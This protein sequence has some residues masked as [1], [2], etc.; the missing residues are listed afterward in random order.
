MTPRRR[1]ARPESN[2]SAKQRVRLSAQ[3][4][5]RFPFGVLIVTLIMRFAIAPS[6]S[7]AVDVLIGVLA[8]SVGVVISIIL[9][10]A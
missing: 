1:I 3:S 2:G 8:A 10:P 7:L 4:L 9:D 6:A 5:I